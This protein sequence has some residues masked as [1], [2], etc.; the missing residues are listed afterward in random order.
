MNCVASAITP[1]PFVPSILE[2]ARLFKPSAAK[3]PTRASEAGMAPP[4]SR[5]VAVN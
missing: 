3:E 4:S 5:F 1:A 2:M